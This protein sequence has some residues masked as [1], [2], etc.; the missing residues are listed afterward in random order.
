MWGGKAVYKQESNKAIKF[1]RTVQQ[2]EKLLTIID[3]EQDLL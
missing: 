3:T 2:K 1:R